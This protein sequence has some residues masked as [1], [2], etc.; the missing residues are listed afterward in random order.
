MKVLRL[1]AFALVLAGAGLLPSCRQRAAPAEDEEVTG[2]EWFEDVTERV[3]LDFVH[4][5]GPTGTYFMPQIMGSGCALFDFD[6]SGRLGIYL[7]QFGGPKSRSTN[8]LYRQLPDGR[9]QDVSAGS[10]LDIAGHCTGVAVG[11]VNNDGLPDVLVTQYGGVR[12]FLNRGRGKFEDVTRQSGLDNPFWATSAAF[13]DL[14]RDGWLDLVVVNYLDYYPSQPCHG[15]GG[16]RDYCEPS[17][18]RGRVTRLFRNLG[19]RGGGREAAVRFEDVTLPSGLGEKAGPGLGVICADFDGDGWPDILV[20][21]DMKANRLWINNGRG[22]HF[23]DEAFERGVAY[24][25]LGQPQSN[26]GVALADVA[27]T[28][29]LD[30]YVTHLTEE[31]HTLWRQGPRGW[32]QDRTVDAGLGAPRWRGTGFGTALADFD[33]DGA[34]DIAVVNGRVTRGPSVPEAPHLKRFWRAYAERNQVFANDGKGRFRDVSPAN[35][36]FCGTPNVARGLAWGDVNNDGG[37]DLL[38]TTVGGRA[39]LFRNVAPRRGHWLLVR[40]LLDGHHGGRDAVGA[41][42]EV[43]AGGR[44]RLGL[45]NPGSSY[46]SSND[47]RAHFGLGKVRRVEAIRVRWPDGSREVFGGGAADRLMTLRQGRGRQMGK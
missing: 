16:R 21:N 6:G 44:K 26:M 47:V 28:G 32:F 10:G 1:L 42:V 37:V 18:F 30:L 36:A 41:E 43:E 45:I 3:G 34:P 38:L 13:V 40:A 25:V 5:A 35:R 19:R 33:N 15:E 20:A 22:T 27:G 17:H 11:D 14:D 31:Y 9:F 4:D 7:L 46:L 8:K 39:R 12:L 29:L 23:R 24:N 2:P